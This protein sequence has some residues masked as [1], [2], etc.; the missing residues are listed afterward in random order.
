MRHTLICLLIA[1]SPTVALAQEAPKGQLFDTAHRQKIY[2]AQKK[3][4]LAAIGYTLIYPGLGNYY[5]EQYVTGTVV[6]MGM[7]FG[8]T[9]LVFGLTTDQSDW[10][11]IGA[12]LGG[13]MYAVGG[14]TSYF[15]VSDYNSELKRALKVADMDRAPGL[16]LAIRF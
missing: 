10:A 13:S 7:V 2:D 8:V 16:V 5:A 1:L 9:C 6:G 12:V 3:S 14:V 15:G 4:E 11:T